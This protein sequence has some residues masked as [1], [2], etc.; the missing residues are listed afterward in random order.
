MPFTRSG[1]RVRVLGGTDAVLE[2]VLSK[3][4]ETT[5]RVWSG[6]RVTHTIREVQNGV[7]MVRDPALTLSSSVPMYAYHSRGLEQDPCKLDIVMTL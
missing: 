1:L 7:R 2:G 4:T 5:R 3:K 6:V